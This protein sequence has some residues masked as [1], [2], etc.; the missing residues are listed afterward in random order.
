MFPT[1]YSNAKDVDRHNG[2]QLWT[3]MFKT[4]IVYKHDSYIPGNKT[5]LFQL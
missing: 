3:G 5:N 4:N 2:S 1:K